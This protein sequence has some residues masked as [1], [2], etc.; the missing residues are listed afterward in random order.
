MDDGDFTNMPLTD[1]WW[2]S[3]ARATAEFSYC[4]STG[5]TLGL[6]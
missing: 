4:R 1:V 3:T 6:T 2:R 5:S